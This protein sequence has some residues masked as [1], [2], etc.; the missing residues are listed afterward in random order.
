MTTKNNKESQIQDLLVDCGEG[1][2]P[3]VADQ[4]QILSGFESLD[5][6]GDVPYSAERL[7]ALRNMVMLEVAPDQA[8]ADVRSASAALDLL[9]T[10]SESR[11]TQTLRL[12]VLQAAEKRGGVAS[13]IRAGWS[14]GW[15]NELLWA[16]SA[17]A[18]VAG[19]MTMM[20]ASGSGQNRSGVWVWGPVTYLGAAALFGLHL[21]RTRGVGAT[22]GAV[23]AGVAGIGFVE[24]F[25]SSSHT[26]GL[27]DD[28]VAPA[29]RAGMMCLTMGGV[30]GLFAALPLLIY[31]RGLPWL[32][33]SMVGAVGGLAGAAMLHMQCP[34]TVT[35]HS[36]VF[37]S[38]GVLVAAFAAAAFAKLL[39]MV[40]DYFRTNGP[41]VS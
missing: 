18:V 14:G 12:R 9:A 23:L 16:V 32:S 15:K 13:G 34:A 11:I 1:D 38:S 20:G 29:F 10:H 35:G 7:A 24:W 8:D 28:G 30:V 27:L 21:L 6:C 25:G 39:S 33:A 22:L 19:M 2:R 4:E 26:S 31:R 40:S 41:A 37:H 5:A 36:V 17:I 3:S